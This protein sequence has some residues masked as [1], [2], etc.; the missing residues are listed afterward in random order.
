MSSAPV[1]RAEATPATAK[2]TAPNM[3]ARIGEMTKD[4]AFKDMMRSQQ[5]MVVDMMYA[6]LSKQLN[7]A[8]EDADGL[9]QLLVERQM[10]LAEGGMALMSGEMSAADRLQ[11]GKELQE[12]KAGYDKKIEEFL[13]AENYATFQQHEDTQGE[14]MQVNLF[15]QSLPAADALGE[16]QEAELI[17]ALHQARKELPDANVID[18]NQTDPSKFTA[19]GIAEMQK[20]LERLQDKYVETAAGVLSATQLEQFKKTMEQQRAMQEMGLKMA[21]K[22]FAEPTPGAKP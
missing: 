6:G 3:F 17:A 21:A 22:M 20:V 5:K 11:K 9:K 13:G 2:E 12:V 7:L 1:A 16:E 10:A 14:R 19:D 15:K 8:P 18:P 4:P